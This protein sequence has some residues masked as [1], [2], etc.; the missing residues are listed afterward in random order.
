MN[1]YIDLAKKAIE[2]YIKNGEVIE[3]SRNLLPELLNKRAGAFVTVHKNG[4]LRGCIGTIAPTKENLAQEII[5]N[6]INT[7]V[8]DYRFNP[9]KEKELADLI[10]E[11]SILHEPKPLEDV[12]AHDPKKHGLIVKT[13]D[14]RSGLLLPDLEG[15]DTFEQQLA[16]AANKGNIDPKKNDLILSY[17]T[18]DKHI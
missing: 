7:A 15:I 1:H 9:I 10:Y 14:G 16:I 4:Q 5:D 6:A 13:K 17:F 2:N 8:R 11:V 18:V 3:P 12:T